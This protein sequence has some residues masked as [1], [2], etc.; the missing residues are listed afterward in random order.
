MLVSLDAYASNTILYFGK[1]VPAGFRR[2]VREETKVR[3]G[4]NGSHYRRLVAFPFH[5]WV[6][7]TAR[8]IRSLRIR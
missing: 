5:C 7:G 8:L 1:S 4:C 3:I 2:V 6:K